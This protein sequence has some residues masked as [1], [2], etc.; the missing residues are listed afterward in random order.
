MAKIRAGCFQFTVRPGDPDRN[1]RRVEYSVA[2]FAAERCQ[3]LVLPE[4]WSCGFVYRQLAS[5]A[6]ET[7]GILRRVQDWSR[8]TGMVIVGSLPEGDGG[9]VFNTAH[10]V[11]ATGAVAGSYRKVH[12]FS[13]HGE[14][15]HFGRGTRALVC[16]TKAGRI[17]VLICYDLRFPELGRRLALDGAHILCIPA[18]WPQARIAHW[19]T[20]TAARAVE[21]QLFVAGCNSHD[22]K[23]KI[24]LGGHSAIISPFGRPLAAAEDGEARLVATLDFDEMEAFRNQIPCFRDRLPEAYGTPAEGTGAGAAS[25]P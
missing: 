10:V 6:R 2:W 1:A 18:Q 7:P 5:M 24:P 14:D 11:D 3:L 22:G 12:L 15:R 17:G 8:T 16:L 9:S 21:N 4:M 23:A 19:Q 20:L 13:L 25:L